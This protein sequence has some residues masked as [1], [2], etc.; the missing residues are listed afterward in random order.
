MLT[1]KRIVNI[2]QKLSI[3]F[4]ILNIFE[5]IFKIK[6][7]W[8]MCIIDNNDCNYNYKF[9]DM[10][11]VNYIEIPILLIIFYIIGII[12]ATSYFLIPYCTSLIIISFIS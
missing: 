8:I 11:N 12:K 9:I 3:I 7:D 1:V 2:W 5:N 4:M 6:L 10:F